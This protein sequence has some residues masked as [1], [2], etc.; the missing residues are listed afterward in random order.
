MNLKLLGLLLV[1]GLCQANVFNIPRIALRLARQFT[2][3]EKL[4][5]PE[6]LGGEDYEMTIEVNKM[7]EDIVD[8]VEDEEQ[9]EKSEDVVLPNMKLESPF[10]MDKEPVVNYPK[11]LKKEFNIPRKEIVYPEDFNENVIEIMD[12]SNERDIDLEPVLKAKVEKGYYE[13]LDSDD[14][15]EDLM[16]EGSWA[17]LSDSDEESSD[18]EFS[19]E[20]FEDNDEEWEEARPFL[21]C[22]CLKKSGKVFESKTAPRE[23]ESENFRANDL[24]SSWD[25]RNVSGVNYCSPTRNQHIPVYCGSCWV[26]G[27]TGALNDRFNVARQGRWPMTQLSPQEIIDCNGKGNCQGGEIGDVLEHAKIQG[28]VEEGCNVYRATNG[29]CNPYHRC[30]SCWP[31]EC[32]S[33]TNYTRYY[34]KDYG[35]VKGRENIMAEIKKGGPIACA[36]GATKKFEYEYVKGV[37]SEKSDLDSNHIISLTGWGVDENGVEYWIARNSWGEAWGELG[38][39]RVVTSKFQNGEGDHYNMGIERDCYFADVDVS[40]LN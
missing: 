29:E 35:Q 9:T 5:A 38:W 26:F 15:I 17:D 3:M 13:S 2:G 1:I 11:M 25:W 36:I 16:D 34:V 21:K 33:L 10:E 18:E 20:Y 28:L 19:E 23:W 32:F 22:G 39:F 4:P 31:N 12:S 37:Y 27:T 7:V 14:K 30:G 24:P 8:S 6:E 40:N